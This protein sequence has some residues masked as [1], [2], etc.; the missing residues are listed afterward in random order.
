MNAV[1]RIARDVS[2]ERTMTITLQMGTWSLD[3][4]VK[5]RVSYPSTWHRGHGVDA[6][7]TVL[8]VTYE[9]GAERKTLP[10]LPG[11][12][13]AIVNQIEADELELN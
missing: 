12:H 11:L 2:P 5:F 8:S 13:D 6:D 1:V 3:A 7:V 4:D 10:M 9:D